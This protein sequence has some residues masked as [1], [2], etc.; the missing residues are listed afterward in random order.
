M[1]NL[2][3][4]KEEK[5]EAEMLEKEDTVPLIQTQTANEED[6]AATDSETDYD[7]DDI[8]PPPPPLVK[9]V[10]RTKTV[11]APVTIPEEPPVVSPSELAPVMTVEDR[12]MILN[13][14][15][16]VE[17]KYDEMISNLVKK[18]GKSK[19]KENVAPQTDEEPKPK[20]ARARSVPELSVATNRRQVMGN[21][22]NWA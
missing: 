4:K 18:S 12:D 10:R 8:P 5:L 13:H 2:L 6:T 3:K 7:T 22:F 15:K 16:N 20:R 17:N 21:L 9:K 19:S 1:A 14:L 11:P